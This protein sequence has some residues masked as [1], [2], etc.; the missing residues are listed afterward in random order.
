M[1]IDSRTALTGILTL[2]LGACGTVDTSPGMVTDVRVVINELVPQNQTPDT[3]GKSYDWVELY[4][5]MARTAVLQG[6]FLSDKLTK[7]YKYELPASAV[8]K[9]G[10]YLVLQ[11]S[12]DTDIPTGVMP[13][14][15]SADGDSVVF[16]SPE[17]KV[18]DS[19]DYV[20]AKAN[21]SFARFPNGS[22]KFTWCA[23]S[24]PDADNGSSCG[25]ATGDATTQ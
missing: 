23:T 3:S 25:N 20:M 22:G 21:Q 16:S 2:A 4:N 13:F 18:I 6:Y 7:W 8:I 9:P 1:N 15:L 19:V 17:G 12:G 11:A 24:T 14:G 10:G 5:P